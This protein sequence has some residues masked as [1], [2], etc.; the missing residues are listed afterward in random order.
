[1][2]FGTSLWSG[3]VAAAVNVLKA[4]AL[5]VA[6]MW[7]Q[8]VA[9]A[10]ISTE[11]WTVTADASEGVLIVGHEKLGTL[12]QD[13]RLNLRAPS[14]WTALRHWSVEK[15]APTSRETSYT[16]LP[17]V[18]RGKPTRSPCACLPKCRCPV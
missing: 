15:T 3:R 2:S 13:V 1:M 6:A 16:V 9:A 5:T 8:V 10:T 4:A 7:T 18:S 12:M 11:G 17:R 14:G